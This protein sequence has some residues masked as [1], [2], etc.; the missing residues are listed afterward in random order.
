MIFKKNFNDD[1]L[2]QNIDKI[3]MITKT[4]NNMAGLCKK[5]FNTKK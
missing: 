2:Q 5:N 1:Y 3:Y 4:E